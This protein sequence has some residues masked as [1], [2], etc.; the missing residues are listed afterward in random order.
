M[1][2]RLRDSIINAVQDLNTW[3]QK[4]VL[5][6]TNGT[7]NDESL[8]S[9]N[10]LDISCAVGANA[11]TPP[12]VDAISQPD[13]YPSNTKYRFNTF[14]K[15]PSGMDQVKAYLTEACSAIG[16]ELITTR[17][18]TP[19]GRHRNETQT[20]HC[21]CEGEVKVDHSDF[22]DGCYSKR[23]TKTETVKETKTSG[24]LRG[25]EDMLMK[26]DKGRRRKSK[27]AKGNNKSSN[28]VSEPAEK[29]P[30]KGA[31][32]KSESAKRK[33]NHPSTEKKITAKNKKVRLDVEGERGSDSTEQQSVAVGHKKRSFDVMESESAAGRTKKKTSTKQSAVYSANQPKK[34]RTESDKSDCN[35][36]ITYFRGKDD[37]IYLSSKSILKH[38]GHPH[39]PPA[40]KK[41]KEKKRSSRYGA[42]THD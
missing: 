22:D 36:K 21:H 31:A 24:Q 39:V 11:V 10:G 13:T 26:D 1:E 28:E 5:S 42:R 12:S 37:Y 41:A 20:L 8:Q 29:S 32:Q 34:R 3:S 16:V 14:F 25:V 7:F 35:M 27:K 38:N 17:G 2:S 15:G 4:I 6:G 18:K 23:D 33:R 9:D 19:P 30:G 40:A